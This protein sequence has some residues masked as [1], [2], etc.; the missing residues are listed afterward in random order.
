MMGPQMTAMAVAAVRLLTARILPLVNPLQ[1]QHPRQHPRQHPHPYPRPHI[2]AHLDWRR[3]DT[4]CE[5]LC[6]IRHCPRLPHFAS[7][8]CIYAA[9]VTTRHYMGM[10]FQVKSSD[11]HGS[12]TAHNAT[13]R[14]ATSELVLS[15]GDGTREDPVDDGICVLRAGAGERIEE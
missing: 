8:N 11:L 3:G 5:I 12:H 4:H 10:R 7:D 1:T 9:R 14:R 2:T 15:T 6:L 13:L